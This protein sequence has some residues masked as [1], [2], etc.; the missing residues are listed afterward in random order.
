M[1]THPIA[2][3]KKKV[4]TYPAKTFSGGGY[5]YDDVLEYRVWV[6][7]ADDANDTDYFKAFA[8]YESAKKYAEN[9]DGSED[10]CVLILQKEYIDEP[11]DGVFVK[12]KKR[13]ITEWLV[14][15]LSDS[16]RDTDSLDKF[17]ADRKAT[18]NTGP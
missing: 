5:F 16:K 2:L 15:W 12:I 4:G 14:P 9:T 8:D 18:P 11:E 3:D 6:H 13:R 7:P 17:I 1:T 10:P